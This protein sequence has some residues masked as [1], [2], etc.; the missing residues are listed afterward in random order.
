M[1]IRLMSAESGEL[2]AAQVLYLQEQLARHGRTTLAVPSFDAM[3]RA[4]RELAR[5]G[6]GLGVEAC[7]PEAW[8]DGAW[9][10]LG[11][12]RVPVRSVQRQML[13]ADA[14]ADARAAGCLAPLS[15]TSGTVRMLARMAR[16]LVVPV[17]G[18]YAKT[19]ERMR[20]EDAVLA[21]S[22]A[23][24]RV[25]ELVGAYA[26]KLD[27]RSLVEP[28]E[29]ALVLAGTFG[30][31]GAE[32]PASL[33][34]VVFAG[35]SGLSGYMVELVASIARTGA[36]V[37][38][39]LEGDERAFAPELVAVFAA[40]G[41]EVEEGTLAAG[42]APDAAA[43][44]GAPAGEFVNGDAAAPAFLEV[45]GPHAKPR[46][47]TRA[48]ERLV[49]EAG[50]ERPVV[51]VV[52]ARP[53]DLAA[54]I[55]D[56]L[57]V[58]GIASTFAR[59]ARF[60]ETGVGRAFTALSDLAER[61]RAAEAGE[62]S[63]TSWWPAPELTDWLYSPLSG[64]D[65]AQARAFDKKV[66]SKRAMGVEGTRRYLQS[67]QGSLN[68]ARK[69]LDAD[70]PRRSV[71][72]VCADVFQFIERGRPISALKGMLEVAQAQPARAFGTVGG[73]AVRA[74]EIACARAAIDLLADEARELDVSQ[75]VAQGALDTVCTVSRVEVLPA[76]ATGQIAE[77]RFMTL[78]EAAELGPGS[79]D[80]VF[81]ADM[82][83]QSYPLSH[84]EGPLATLSARLSMPRIALEPAALLRER[85]AAARRAAAGPVC[86]ARVTHDRQAKDRYPAAIW[87]ELVSAAGA[88]PA[89]VGESEVVADFDPAFGE[90]LRTEHVVCAAPQYLGEAARPYVVLKQRASESPSALEDAAG[91]DELVPRL[92]SAS[93]IEAYASCPLCWFISSR[94]HPLALDAGFGNMEKGNFVHDVLYRFHVELREE[95]EPRVTRENLD[96][97][98]ELLGRVFAQ[99]RAEHACGKTSSSAPLVP[100]SSAEDAQIDEILPQLRS[101]VRYEAEALAPFRPA[102]LEYSFNELGVTYAGRPLGGRID[103]VDVDAEGRAVVIDYKHRNDVNPFRLSDPTAP[104]KQGLRAADDPRWLPEHTQTLI[105]AQAIRRALGLD[106]RAALYF[107]TKGKRPVMRGA[108][109]AELV[110]V[111][112]GDGRIPGLR[113]GFPGEEGSMT[114]EELLDRTEEGIAERLLEMDAGIVTAAPDPLGRCAYNHSHGFTRREA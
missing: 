52:S 97:A 27:A 86:L 79:V 36:E 35:V 64:A 28:S 43:H 85:V 24:E 93:Q 70:D 32:L 14:V 53:A 18:A 106:A 80:A 92:T 111:E 91:D 113:D 87:T 76:D 49:R 33:R 62:T 48:I 34:S 7:T 108:A 63:D 81:F 30:R 112:P 90:A 50:V 84:E 41:C 9:A 74:S 23:E 94:V 17:A 12:G 1:A 71:P 8:L 101:V 82:D 19:G 77:A 69:K 110:E 65:A 5:A 78:E 3:A 38:F 39:L 15:D 60:G 83:I 21:E 88:E 100:L 2:A 4:R 29:A 73:R 96:R 45:A 11:D 56:R 55:S 6:V 46:A 67:V 107:A 25:F 114:F 103:R 89:C 66:R 104:D 44:A 42:A 26:C 109:S 47:Y 57:S 105:Y 99:V 54:E 98:L 31:D 68:A 37:S 95:G 51:A 102:Y 61:M 22:A 10:L 59:L 13:M 72:C 75:A 40:A 58:L 16:D 20:A